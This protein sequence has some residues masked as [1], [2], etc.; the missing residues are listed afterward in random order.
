MIY[1][2]QVS[3][4]NN[5]YPTVV[6]FVTLDEATIYYEKVSRDYKGEYLVTL[7]QLI[8]CAGEPEYP[9]IEWR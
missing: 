8:S 9:E 2:Y 3:V 5:Y 1:K 4:F 7:T 6:L